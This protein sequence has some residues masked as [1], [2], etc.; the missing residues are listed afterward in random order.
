[1]AGQRSRRSALLL[2]TLVG[3]V[4]ACAHAPPATGNRAPGA[5]VDPN[6]PDVNCQLY[7]TVDCRISAG[8]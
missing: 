2:I 7:N 4:A 3:L 6:N 8:G 5:T 1:M